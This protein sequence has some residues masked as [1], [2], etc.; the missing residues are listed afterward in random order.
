MISLNFNF[1]YVYL[2]YYMG[3]GVGYDLSHKLMLLA[4]DKELLNE[5]NAA[6]FDGTFGS[7]LAYLKQL[8]WLILM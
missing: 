2:A 1:C 5:A 6:D 8:N 4:N 3:L 7:Y